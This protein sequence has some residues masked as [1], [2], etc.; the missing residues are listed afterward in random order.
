MGLPSI[1]ALFKK[2]QVSHMCRLISSQYP[3]VHY[4]ATQLTI[5]E[6]QKNRMKFKPMTVVRDALAEDPGRKLSKVARSMFM[7]DDSEERYALLMASEKQ[8]EA[9]RIAEGEATTE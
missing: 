4:S 8:S 7:D 3:A 9:L 1:V 5:S 2:Q 6:Q